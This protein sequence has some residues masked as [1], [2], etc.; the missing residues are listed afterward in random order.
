MPAVPITDFAATAEGAA[1]YRAYDRVLEKWPADVTSTDLD[2]EYGTTRVNSCGPDGAPPV[3]LLPGGG[4]TSTVWFRNVAAIAARHRVH[5]IDLIG[6]AGRSIADGTPIKSTS[7]LLSWLTTVVDGVG[8]ESF[9]LIGHSYGAMIALA[10]ALRTPDRVEKLILLDPT[11]CFA[12]MRPRYLAR[13][14]PVLL[15]PSEKRQRSFIVWETNGHAIDEHWL[16]LSAQGAAYFPA[17]KTVV[18]PRPE[19]AHLRSMKPDTTIIL[20]ADSKAHD[21]RRV[22]ADIAKTHRRIRVV[23]L[24]EATHHTMPMTPAAALDTELIGALHPQR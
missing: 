8:A 3:V 22:A 10:Y 23:T 13:A 9:G 21:S 4:A 14:L 6:D 11:S 20:A 19:P 16:D 7:T 24:D 18:P 5:A 1:F 2:S 15:R 17:T 12:G